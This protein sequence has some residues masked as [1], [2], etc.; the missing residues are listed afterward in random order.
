[1]KL[2]I[3]YQNSIVIIKNVKVSLQNQ[4]HTTPPCV[5]VNQHTVNKMAKL[6]LHRDIS[7]DLLK[8]AHS[9]MSELELF[10]CSIIESYFET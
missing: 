10:N 8:V 6:I 4:L 7:K 3:F 5:S 9:L 2:T 1:M